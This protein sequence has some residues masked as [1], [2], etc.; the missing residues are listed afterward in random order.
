M[1][2]SFESDW[3]TLRAGAD[4]AA[5][6]ATLAL[7]LERRLA[8]GAG[9]GP[10]TIL[11]LG[12]GNGNNMRLLGAAM[13][14]PQRWRLVDAD[15]ALLEEARRHAPAHLAVET[16]VGDLAGDIDA[17]LDPRADAVTAS[18]LFDLCSA[19]WLD[20][21]VEGLAARCLP[22]LGVLT[23]DGRQ[24]WAGEMAEDAAVLEAFHADHH[25]DK[26]LGIAL[27]PQAHD[28]LAHALRAAGYRVQ[29]ADSAWCL[30]RP[31]DAALIEALADGT[32]RAVAPA[33]GPAAERWRLERRA[34][35]A[36]TIGHRDLLA[37]PP[38]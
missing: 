36:V 21:F 4:R 26:G 10:V 16:V 18:A 23:Y 25:R 20:R 38:D 8:E 35:T 9:D 29:E 6:S 14:L 11:D 24:D 13:S 28:H 12:A 22:L 27:G 5:R 33:L 34:A 3:L 7:L 17:L 19:A 37:T 1:A 31:D 32:S 30:S 2:E 15:E